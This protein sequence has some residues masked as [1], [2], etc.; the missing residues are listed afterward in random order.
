MAITARHPTTDRKIFVID[1]NATHLD[2]DSGEPVPAPTA[3]VRVEPHKRRAWFWYIFMLAPT[4]LAA[5][6]AYG[7]ANDR[8]QAEAKFVIRNS[9]ATDAVNGLGLGFNQILE[10]AGQDEGYIATNFI[11]SRDALIYLAERFPVRSM[12][13]PPRWDPFF[14]FPGLFFNSTQEG[15]FKHYLRFVDATYQINGRLVSLRVVAFSPADAAAIASALLAATEELVNRL[16]RRP[17][18]AAVAAA[19][20]NLEQSRNRAF[21]A[22]EALTAWRNRE[23]MI[24][25]TRMAAIYVE[26]VARLSV[27]LAQL[28]AQISEIEHSAPRSPQ[29]MP[30]RARA[31]S[32]SQQVEI[33]RR[34][35]AAGDMGFADRLGVYERL[36]L[37][38]TFAERSFELAQSG[39]EA[40]RREAEQQKLFVE[41]IVQP[42][43]PDWPLFPRRWLIVLVVLFF[44]IFI[45]IIFRA[46]F[47]DTKSHVRNY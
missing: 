17:G 37:E 36:Y 21:Q 31:T 22:Q 41:Q 19:S 6:Y 30:L 32:L 16:N 9:G 2:G 39:L 27:E 4:F 24:D 34:A 46:L 44:N 13:Q 11:L 29:L 3:D 40:A 25:P 5:V 23:R 14:Q 15:A 26:T 33:E 20:A 10:G 28:Q 42:H 8:F 47:L 1:L 18:A 45:V 43:A 35:L 7:F 12:L 38:H